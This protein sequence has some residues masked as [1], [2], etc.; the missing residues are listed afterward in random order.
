MPASH[1]LCYDP[2]RGIIPRLQPFSSRGH[3]R[4]DVTRSFTA[5][6]VTKTNMSRYDRK[7]L[8]RRRNQVCLPLL[9]ILWTPRPL[10]PPPALRTQRP[11]KLFATLA[12]QEMMKRNYCKFTDCFLFPELVRTSREPIRPTWSIPVLVLL[13][14]IPA[15]HEVPCIHSISELTPENWR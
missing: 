14:A 9:W 11:E 4:S 10:S 13:P 15:E 5:S 7:H 3:E 6:L 8:S 1:L 2:C 12:V